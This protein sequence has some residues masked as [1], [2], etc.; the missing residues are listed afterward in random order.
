MTAFGRGSAPYGDGAWQVEL[1]CVNSKFLDCQLR[2]PASLAPMEEGIKKYIGSRLKRGRVNIFIA[3]KGVTAASQTLS[4]NRP[5]LEEYKKVAAQLQA[6][7]GTGF[8]KPDWACLLTNREL[9]LSSEKEEDEQSIWDSLSPA[10]EQ[11]LAEACAMRQAEG[12]YLA[13]DLTG[14]LTLLA[15][16][17][18][19]LEEISP[20]IITTYQQRL[21]ERISKL[22]QEPI[23]PELQQRLAQEVAVVAD[24]CDIS[25]ELVRTR[26]HLAQFRSFLQAEEPV[27]RKL[28]FL[29]QELNREANTIGSKSP[30]A[31]AMNLVVSLKAELE[32]VRE[33]VQNIE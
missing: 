5:L 23:T 26:S 30:D 17:I 29:T 20:L 33:Q 32:R 10:L 3:L 1:K 31:R 24:K 28:D 12:A 4:L 22:L 27:G 15:G 21:Q 7:L 16:V 14:R 18:D 9:V 2:A 6:E 19:Q 13:E 25:E 11:A 8:T